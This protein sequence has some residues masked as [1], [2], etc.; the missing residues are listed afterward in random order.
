MK[1][2]LW[3][4]LCSLLILTLITG[5]AGSE[6]NEDQENKDGVT[7]MAEVLENNGTSLLVEPQPGSKELSSAD[8]IVIHISEET[9]LKAGD[10]GTLAVEDI[11]IGQRVEIAYSGAIAESYPAQINSTYSI[12][13][14]EQQVFVA[15][16]ENFRIMTYIDKLDFKENEE[17]KLYSTIEYIGTE[18]AITIWSGDPYLN[19]TIFDGTD[20]YSQGIA[21][22]ILKTTE[23]KKGEVYTLPFVKNGGFSQDDP[24]AKFWEQYFSEK[25]LRLP[26][27]NYTFRAY[28]DFHLDP[29]LKES[30]NLETEFQITVN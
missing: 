18:D 30:V 25:E 22:S 21:L 19:Y 10:S 6:R 20:Y 29:D 9:I 26:K 28:T 3:V 17:I 16:N 8:K 23:L 12:T 14:V 13:L 11:E 27:G 2:Y 7:F 5:C 1:K 4:F 15:E 24:K